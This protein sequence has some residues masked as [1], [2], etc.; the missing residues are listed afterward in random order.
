MPLISAITTCKGRLE[1]LKQTLPPLMRSGMEV[2]VVDYD[3]PEGAGTW[4]REHHP[5]ARLVAVAGRPRFNAAEARNLGAAAAAGEWLLFVDADV[6]VDPRLAGAVGP[7]LSD[8]GAFLLADPRPDELWGVL[9]MARATFDLIGGYDE[10]FE[11]WGVED[12][13]IIERLG[14]RG[15]REGRLPAAMFSP[16]THG[17]A[18]RTRFHAITDMKLSATINNVYRIAKNDLA[19]LGQW[20][21]PKDRLR[22]YAS[23]RDALVSPSGV[24]TIQVPYRATGLPNFDVYG[25]LSYDFKRRET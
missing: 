17:D 2:V 12:V 25:S 3:C 1:H 20:L 4:V 11:G 5:E 9:A 7:L 21:E 23:I 16:I 10:A 18:E 22:L 13:D 24:R 15:F 6:F 14:I 8:P 19:R